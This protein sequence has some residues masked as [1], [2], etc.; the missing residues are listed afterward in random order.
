MGIAADGRLYY[1]P[2][3]DNPR[4]KR[5][6][7]I[8]ERHGSTEKAELAARELMRRRGLAIEL[9]VPA[10][11]TWRGLCQEWHD[12][13]WPSDVIPTGERP[14]YNKR[15]SAINVWIIPSIGDVPLVDT[16]LSTLVRVVDALRREGIGRGHFNYVIGLAEEIAEWAAARGKLPSEP[17]GS[18]YLKKAELKRQRR[19][20][21]PRSGKA[22]SGIRLSVDDVPTWDDVCALA[23]AF[24][25]AMRTRGVDERV[26]HQFARAV[27]IQAGTGLRLCELLGLTVDQVDLD[28]GL[29]NVD[30][31]LNRYTR[32]VPGE[33]MPTTTPKHG[34]VR[35]AVAWSKIRDDLTEAVNEAEDGILFAP[36]KGQMH[37][38]DAVG[39]ALMRARE[40]AGWR[41]SAHYLRHH[42][43]SYSIAPVA[44]GGIGMSAPDVQAS[45]GHRNLTTTLDTYVHR[46][47]QRQGWVGH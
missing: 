38:A 28:A 16:N 29:V 5:G 32:W 9:G 46:V 11:A 17:F 4:G 10:D 14:T 47:R 18:T 43:G 8:E 6:K 31:Q 22:E 25:R 39:T 24:G 15:V 30:R 7:R 44:D 2:L 34:S 13:T 41:W 1:Y 33:P 26:E 3:P 21:F 23:Q 36:T 20:Q 37:F 40:A 12:Y 27:R 42:Y 45:M 19:S 35:L